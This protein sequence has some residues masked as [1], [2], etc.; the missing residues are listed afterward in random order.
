MLTVFLASKVED[1][2]C[3][4]MLSVQQR[5]LNLQVSAADLSN[6]LSTLELS[7]NPRKPGEGPSQRAGK[8]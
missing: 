7:A 2:S 8:L 1:G 5:S 3:R 4:I 6:V